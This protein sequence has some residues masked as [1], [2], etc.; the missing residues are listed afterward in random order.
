MWGI[1]YAPTTMDPLQSLRFD[2]MHCL[3][4]GLIKDHFLDLFPRL[5]LL[6]ADACENFTLF[7]RSILRG[8]AMELIPKLARRR[9]AGD[10]QEIWQTRWK[11]W[12]SA[13]QKLNAY[14]LLPLFAHPYRAA[15]GAHYDCLLVSVAAIRLSLQHSLSVADAF[16]LQRLTRA[17]VFQQL[18]TSRASLTASINRHVAMDHLSDPAYIAKMGSPRNLQCFAFENVIFQLKRT[19]TRNSNGHAVATSVLNWERRKSLLASFEPPVPLQLRTNVPTTPLISVRDLPVPPPNCGGRSLGEL[20]AAH[21]VQELV[22]KQ[23]VPLDFDLVDG[24]THG[25]NL[26]TTATQ[27]AFVILKPSR[28]YRLRADSHVHAAGVVRLRAL[29]QPLIMRSVPGGGGHQC[30]V[31]CICEEFVDAVRCLTD[32]NWKLLRG[33]G[34]VLL[35]KVT[36]IGHEVVLAHGTEFQDLCCVVREYN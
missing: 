15:L 32:T 19:I 24:V 26:K 16:E 9:P 21:V 5:L 17:A 22:V 29:F 10:R 25:W 30:D 8:T 28:C 11:R 31:V 4:Q 36:E 3:M 14:L 35:C 12:F 33:T 20:L 18:V 27:N 13:H 1:A 23:L 2:P 6:E 7:A 34:T